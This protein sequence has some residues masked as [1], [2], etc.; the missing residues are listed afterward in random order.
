MK[1]LKLLL[2]AIVGLF[3]A[4]LMS[5]FGLCVYAIVG[6]GFG[7]LATIV[8]SP[9]LLGSLGVVKFLILPLLGGF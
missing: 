4:L 9:I 2:N 6:L 1:S 7:A 8:V 5:I 3:K